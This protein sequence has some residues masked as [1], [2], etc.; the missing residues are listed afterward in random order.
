MAV[1]DGA[2]DKSGIRYEWAG[3]TVSSGRFAAQVVAGAVR[4]LEPCVSAR[5]AVTFVTARLDAAVLARQP[6][7][8]RHDRPACALVMYSRPHHEVWSVGDCSWAF[9]GVEHRGGKKIDDLTA[10]L[11]ADVTEAH[12]ADGWRPE[13][14]ADLDPGRQAIQSLLAFQGL[15]ANRIHELGYAAVN[16]T[17]VPD[18][19]VG[20]TPL[21]G[22]GVLVLTSDGYPEILDSRES[23]DRR[24]LDLV[25]QDPLCIGPLRGPKAVAPGATTY[26]DRTWVSLRVG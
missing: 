15:F 1:I 3:E 2:T 17:P 21:A 12:L 23:S 13:V 9:N 14:L 11:R 16:G 19:H 7:I 25:R 26:D 5:E 4:E 8:G 18:V 20:V 22:S 24:L 10:S 6:A